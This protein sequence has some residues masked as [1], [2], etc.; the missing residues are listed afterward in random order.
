MYSRQC[1]FILPHLCLMSDTC[2][3]MSD[4]CCVSFYNKRNALPKLSRKHKEMNLYPLCFAIHFSSL[5]V[6]ET[7]FPGLGLYS[8]ILSSALFFA[9][10]FTL[11]PCAPPPRG[12]GFKSK[13]LSSGQDQVPKLLRFLQIFLLSQIFL[14]PTLCRKACTSR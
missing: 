11:P 8:T 5:S 2:P 7:E 13:Q 4:N 12:F 6:L 3:R 1:R 9:S 10:P 14:S